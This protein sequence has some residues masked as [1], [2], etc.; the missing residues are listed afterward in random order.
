METEMNN[1][2]IYVD[3]DNISP[4]IWKRKIKNMFNIMGKIIIKK[5]FGDFTRPKLSKWDKISRNDGFRIIH[6]TNIPKK[7]ST[8]ICLITDLI[9][10]YH[11]KKYIDTFIIISSDSDYSYPIKKLKENNKNVIIVGHSHTPDKL[12]KSCTKFINIDNIKNSQKNYTSNSDNSSS[13]KEEHISM[14]KSDNSESISEDDKSNYEPKKK[15]SKNNFNKYNEKYTLLSIF[16]KKPRLTISQLKA[17]I[18]KYKKKYKKKEW[19]NF[20]AYLKNK[21]K[22][23]FRIKK[24]KNAVIIIYIGNITNILK[25]MFKNKN[26]YYL[27]KIKDILKKKINFNQRN[28]GYKTMSLFLNDI[29][30]QLKI[31][32]LKDNLTKIVE[33]K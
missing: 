12:K 5:S 1:L 4:K 7:N 30:P 25:E 18:K 31:K 16:S 24:T 11:E 6:C 32:I 10:D 19:C 3:C 20:D 9:S 33:Y 29:Y 14:T 28:Y 26:K 17:L 8:D 22:N 21:Y 27:S 2:A 13:S 15:K 23:Y